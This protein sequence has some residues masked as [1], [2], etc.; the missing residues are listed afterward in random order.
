[1]DSK[2]AFTYTMKLWRVA[3]RFDFFRP[4]EDLLQGIQ[5]VCKCK[6]DK[7]ANWEIKKNRFDIISKKLEKYHLCLCELQAYWSLETGFH[8]HP[9]QYPL[10]M[11]FTQSDNPAFEACNLHKMTC[12][13][14]KKSLKVNDKNTICILQALHYIG[15]THTPTKKGIFYIPTTPS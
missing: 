8:H 14:H 4:T 11:V 3:R 15:H 13:R 5:S 6:W 2:K 1:M 9:T 10:K 12:V 7:L